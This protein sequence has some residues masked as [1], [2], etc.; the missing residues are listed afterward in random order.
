MFNN[1]IVAHRAPSGFQS[2]LGSREKDR[3]PKSSP[4]LRRASVIMLDVHD[5][6]SCNDL[7]CLLSNLFIFSTLVTHLS[8][9][10]E[11]FAITITKQFVKSIPCLL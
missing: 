5:W 2:T 9:C 6:I 11:M 8:V 1:L 10:P 7:R 3:S 4:P